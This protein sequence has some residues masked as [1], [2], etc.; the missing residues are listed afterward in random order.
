MVGI[1]KCISATHVNFVHDGAAMS[2]QRT[3]AFELLN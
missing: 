2:G 1:W 3:L